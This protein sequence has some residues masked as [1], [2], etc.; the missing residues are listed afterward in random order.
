VVEGAETVIAT[1]T[2]S[3]TH[4]IGPASTATVTIADGN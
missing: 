3:P 4:V 1:I 2:P